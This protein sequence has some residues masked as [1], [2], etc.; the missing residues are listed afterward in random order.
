LRIVLWGDLTIWLSVLLA[1]LLIVVI[2][3]VVLATRHQRRR[4]HGGTGGSVSDWGEGLALAYELRREVKRL[5]EENQRLW[6]ERAELVKVF[7]RVVEFLQEVGQISGKSLGPKR[8]TTKPCRES[9]ITSGPK[10]WEAN[11]ARRWPS[12]TKQGDGEY[13]PGT[14]GM[15][16]AC[17][18]PLLK[19]GG[20]A[21][22]G[23]CRARP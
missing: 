5:S 15:C 4:E 9:G 21:P 7:G 8:E 19:E 12:R 10:V 11:D 1:G 22:S 23:D 17:E 6:A 2:V 3:G 18:Q 14:G 20:S 13:G 16:V